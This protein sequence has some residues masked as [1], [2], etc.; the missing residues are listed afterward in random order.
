[1]KTDRHYH[2][3]KGGAPQ[4]AGKVRGDQWGGEEEGSVSC[5]AEGLQS[6][7]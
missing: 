6:G 4:A 2:L 7:V 3:S 1:M 5:R